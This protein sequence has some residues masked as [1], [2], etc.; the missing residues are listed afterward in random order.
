MKKNDVLRINSYADD[1]IEALAAS[2]FS[3]LPDA[4]EH[5]ASAFL[6]SVGALTH[7]GYQIMGPPSVPPLNELVRAVARGRDR[8]R[9]NRKETPDVAGP[10]G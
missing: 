6:C 4:Q 7:V 9:M 8:R 10:T 5:A 1:L 3:E 2:M